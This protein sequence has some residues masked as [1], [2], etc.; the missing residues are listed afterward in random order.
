VSADSEE[1][2]TITSKGKTIDAV[3]TFE[4]TA[5]H[6]TRRTDKFSVG[7]YIKDGAIISKNSLLADKDAPVSSLDLDIT[8]RGEGINAVIANGKGTDLTLTGSISASD[9][10]DGKNASDFN[11]LGAMIVA[12]GYAKVK[13]DSMNI[14]T[15]GFSRAAFISDTHGQILVKDSTVTTMGANPLTQA[16]KGYV[17]SAD[18][19]IMISPPWVLGIQ[20]GI[21]SANVLGQK[22]TLTIIGSKISSG[23]WAL[24]STDGCTS[25]VTNVLDSILEILPASEGGMSSGSFPYSSKYG[26]GYGTYLI[27]NAVQYFYGATISGTTYAIKGKD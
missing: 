16:Y 3:T 7:Y 13:V 23:G 26:S 19:N 12:H 21:R 22:A 15:K 11:G 9:N 5:T 20:G 14:Y 24:L 2:K 8:A 25:P 18:T 6:Y 10:G 17:N 27:G 1:A 4:G